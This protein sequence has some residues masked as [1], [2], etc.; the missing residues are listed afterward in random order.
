[1]DNYNN[2]H[3][4]QPVEYGGTDLEKS[5][6]VMILI[7]GRGAT[8]GDILRLADQ[9]RQ[10]GLA[11]VAPK[12]ANH[13]WY[14]YSFLTPRDKNEPH[15]SSALEKVRETVSILK[16]EG[17]QS[18]QIYLLG[19]SQGACLAL[20]YAATHPKKYAGVFCLSGGL[21]GSTVRK[22]DYPG[23]L[24]QTPIFLGCSDRDR[25]IPLE[26]VHESAEILQSM[27]AQLEKRIYP[28]MP[29]TVNEDEILYINKTLSGNR[30]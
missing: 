18:H 12:A 1:M 9:F 30:A 21:I 13:T 3:H 24:E 20:E 27:N 10:P 16:S 19:F 6:E 29:H 17:F 26:R 25:H 7:H 15:L 2:P 28:G 11:F 22:E 5:S 14:P 8:P 4:Q 23:D